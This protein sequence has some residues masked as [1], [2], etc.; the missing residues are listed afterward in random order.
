M[1]Y[2]F[3]QLDS[4]FFMRIFSLVVASALLASSV[5]F[6]STRPARADILVKIGEP[7]A[8]LGDS[9][10]RDGAANPGG[11]V[12]LVE[13]GLASQGVNVTIIPSGV[14][15]H[16][17]KDMLDRV[18]KDVLSKKPTW[19]TLNCG[20][21]DVWRGK[22]ELEDYKKNVTAIL[23]RAQAAGV[24]V[25]VLTATPIY[26]PITN[27]HNTKLAGYNDFL[28]QTAKAR[29]LPLADVNA[30]MIA[31]LTA[32]EKAGIKRSL[33]TDGVHMNLHG[34]M[35]MAKAVLATFG[36]T[37]SQIAATQAK[38]NDTPGIFETTAKIKLSASQLASLRAY[39][40]VQ[41]KSPENA[42]SEVSTTAVIRALQ[43]APSGPATRQPT[44]A[45]PN[46]NDTA[47]ITETTA[48]VKLSASQMAALEAY[49]A[50]QSKPVDTVVSEISTAAVISALK[51][52]SVASNPTHINSAAVPSNRGTESY[53]QALNAEAKKGN[54]D[55]LF[56]GD[57]IT[58]AWKSE[59][60]GPWDER[61]APLKAA[62]FG[63]GG[64]K[65]EHVLWR[66]QNGNLDGIKPK[67]V[68]L[69]IGTNNVGRISS[70]DIAWGISAVV[71]EIN[72]RLPES[73]VLLMGL[74]PRGETPEDKIRIQVKEVNEMISK[75]D[76]G[77]QVFFTDIGAQMLLPNGQISKEYLP[78][79]LH[80]SGMG[81][82]LWAESI[83]PK[84]DKFMK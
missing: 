3:D 33:T 81:Y 69:L 2:S 37:P 14:G 67:V 28:R 8:F 72:A 63:L 1:V 12:R 7:V 52:A 35:V 21:N 60:R 10:T 45:Q 54:I 42:A 64:D 59:G 48:K 6:L 50:T 25:L 40:A 27:A 20:V 58:Q 82:K 53:H 31:E 46:G 41:Y 5:L 49:A 24:K 71:R 43:T 79:L 13:S 22:V 38:W 4:K 44:I 73:K 57:S 56:I 39:G 29:K 66:L 78:D 65:I 9:I 68:V 32:L 23:D 34:N 19:M 16:S 77:K 15:G 36:L 84:I 80:L 55:L 76:D 47:G 26:L 17:S 61:F 75:L 62:N 30:A 70:E 18:E 74:F 11:W 51:I 83:Q